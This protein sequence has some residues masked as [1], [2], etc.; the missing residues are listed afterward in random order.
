MLSDRYCGA[1]SVCTRCIIRHKWS[2]T[3]SA[4]SATAPAAV[5]ELLGHTGIGWEQVELLHSGHTA[6]VQWYIATGWLAQSYN[7]PAGKVWKRKPAE[8]RLP[9]RRNVWSAVND[10]AGRNSCWRPWKRV[11]SSKAQCRVGRQDCEPTSL[12]GWCWSRLSGSAHFLELYR[13]PS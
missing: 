4:T 1:R 7:S 5:L 2:C 8:L 10:A 3:R 11:C 12:A 9:D 6:V 13:G